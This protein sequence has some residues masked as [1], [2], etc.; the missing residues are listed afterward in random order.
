[1]SHRLNNVVEVFFSWF[2]LILFKEKSKLLKSIIN[3]VLDFYFASFYVY[4]KISTVFFEFQPKTDLIFFLVD[5]FS[6]YFGFFHLRHNL[7]NVI[8]H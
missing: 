8:L 4:K 5:W 2:I 1:M 3:T 6:I 7:D